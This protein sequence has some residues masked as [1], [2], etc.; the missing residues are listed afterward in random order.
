MEYQTVDKFGLKEI[1]DLEPMF[2]VV[3]HKGSPAV[4]KETIALI[5]RKKLKDTPKDDWL[6]VRGQSKKE[7][8]GSL[9]YVKETAEDEAFKI[10]KLS[11]HPKLEDYKGNYK[12][13]LLIIA[14]FTDAELVS[15]VSMNA[16]KISNEE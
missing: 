10:N 1:G 16:H 3:H 7:F 4:V 11:Y 15:F 13:A 8:L 5:V 2:Q 12:K 9:Y 14:N 6:R